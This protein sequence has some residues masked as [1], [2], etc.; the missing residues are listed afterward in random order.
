MSYRNY[1]VVKP[2]SVISGP[3]IIWSHGD[4]EFII[5]SVQGCRAAIKPLTNQTWGQPL[6]VPEERAH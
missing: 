6:R 1:M 5:L 4:S 2:K 3:F